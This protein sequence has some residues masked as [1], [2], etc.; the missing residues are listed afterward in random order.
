MTAPQFIAFLEQK[1]TAY[2]RKIMPENSRFSATK[3]LRMTWSGPFRRI[4]VSRFAQPE[5]RICGLG[6][7]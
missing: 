3:G 6:K 2:A 7:G 5:R 4:G 1:L